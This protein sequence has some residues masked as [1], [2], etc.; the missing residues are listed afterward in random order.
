MSLDNKAKWLLA[1]LAASLALNLFLVGALA[2][3]LSDPFHL[4]TPDGARASF[5]ATLR[6]LPPAERLRFDEAIRERGPQLRDLGRRL[7]E[8]GA[9]ARAAMR[10]QPYSPSDLDRALAA[11][12]RD[13]D[14]LQTVLHAQVVIGLGRLS[15]ASRA[16]LAEPPAR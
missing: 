10:A 3:R 15:P 2:G 11:V 13:T 16:R 7:A 12:R 9:Q 4:R 6:Q 1:A 14:A 8:D 5:R